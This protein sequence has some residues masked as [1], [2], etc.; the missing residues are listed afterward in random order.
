[1][2]RKEVIIAIDPDIDK[3][4]L[5]V[6]LPRE[7][8]LSVYDFTLPEMVE[9]F[10]EIKSIYEKEGITYVIIVE[11]SY[12]IQANWHLEWNDSKR[13]AAAKGKQVGRNHEIGRQIVEFCKYLD[14]PYEEKKPLSKCWAGKDGKITAEELEMLL[15][16]T[17]I[18]PLTTRT[19]QEKRDA[20][21]LALDRSG[22]PLRM[23]KKQR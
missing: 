20:A 19:N 13:K 21:L 11:A 12:L 22:L 6:L 18:K 5:A 14:L 10:R 8:Q 9:F 17:G 23:G 16:G 15:D 7:K 1:M 4:G 2:T 3:S